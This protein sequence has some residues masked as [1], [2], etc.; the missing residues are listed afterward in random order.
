MTPLAIF[1]HDS[2]LLASGEELSAAVAVGIDKDRGGEVSGPGGL[3][4][5]VS[6]K[7]RDYRSTAR[8]QYERQLARQGRF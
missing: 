7:G 1:Q 2:K 4:K 5:D 8:S 6:E 3:E